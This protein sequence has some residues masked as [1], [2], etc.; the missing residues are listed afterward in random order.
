MKDFCVTINGKQMRVRFVWSQ[1][2]ARSAY[3]EQAYSSDSGKD[4]GEELDHD[5]HARQVARRL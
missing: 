5:I 4:M 3:W 2:T 1:I